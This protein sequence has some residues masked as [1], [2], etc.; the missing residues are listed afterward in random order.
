MFY[1]E[2]CPYGITTISDGDRLVQFPTKRERDEW[3]SA[4]DN[5]VAATTREVSHRY[6][7]AD[8]KNENRCVKMKDDPG[9]CFI[10]HK[11]NY[12]F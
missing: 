6:N 7:F 4:H 10:W 8:F 2:F 3:V 1:A 12:K 5:S 11:P 9:V